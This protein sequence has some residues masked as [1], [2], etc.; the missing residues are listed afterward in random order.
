MEYMDEDTEESE[1]QSEEKEQTEDIQESQKV[2]I[3]EENRVR[4]RSETI[5][6]EKSSDIVG[7]FYLRAEN[8]E[9]F[10]EE[11]TV[12]VVEVPVKDHKKPEV[13]EAKGK[14]IQNLKDYDTFEEVE[15]EGQERVGSR[16]VITKKEKHDGQKTQY[17]ARLVAKGFHE[18]VKPQ[19][20]S[21][22]AMR[23]SFKLFCA[24][25]ANENF[26]VKSIDISAAFL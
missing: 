17:K 10:K 7:A 16:W 15:D 11:I 8:E 9:C 23:E 6:R 21:P 5:R 19:A 12:H 4:T 18:K 2:E 3:P 24:V 20:D 25:A 22:T 14:E 1:E 26:G 13:V